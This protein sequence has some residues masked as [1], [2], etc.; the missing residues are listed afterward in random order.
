MTT[1][2]KL[3]IEKLLEGC[4]IGPAGG[5]FRLRDPEG[6]PILKVGRRTVDYLVKWDLVRRRKGLLWIDKRKVRQLHGNSF[7]KRRYR[8]NARAAKT[9]NTPPPCRRRKRS[10]LTD[11]SSK[12]QNV[13]GRIKRHF[14]GGY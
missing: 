10:G 14:V 6:R 12:S 8:E 2:Q 1:T 4:A 13:Y 9:K 5:T 3:V 7:T 11:Y